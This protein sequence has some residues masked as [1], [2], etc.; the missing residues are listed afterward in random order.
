MAARSAVIRRALPHPG[1]PRRA[2]ASRAP[3]PRTGRAR[4]RSWWGG[5]RR[6]G[7]GR[8]FR[9]DA[10][11]RIT[12]SASRA[13]ADRHG[14]EPKAAKGV[15]CTPRP[16]SAAMQVSRGPCPRPCRST[17]SVGFAA[18]TADNA[19]NVKVGAGDFALGIRDGVAILLKIQCL[20][21]IFG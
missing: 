11:R 4:G 12:Q 16:R 5:A 20:T 2:T 10:Q 18:A 13:G 15:A 8:S 3:A 6:G 9:L 17:G 14:T 7:P 21:N 1:P 19:D